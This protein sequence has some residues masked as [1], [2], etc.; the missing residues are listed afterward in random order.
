MTHYKSV[1]CALKVCNATKSTILYRTNQLTATYMYRFPGTPWRPGDSAHLHSTLNVFL[2]FSCW[3]QI[4]GL[5]LTTVSGL[6]TMLTDC[7]VVVRKIV[8]ALK[9]I[10]AKLVH[11]G[12]RDNHFVEDY[13]FVEVETQTQLIL[14]VV[15]D[16]HG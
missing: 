10:Q 11:C 6:A 12:S 13:H 1:L 2:L 16:C 9:L 14:A 7:R 8:Q 4:S 3:T 15:V 5:G